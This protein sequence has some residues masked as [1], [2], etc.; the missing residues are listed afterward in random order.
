MKKF[1]VKSLYRN[2]EEEGEGEETDDNSNTNED[3][4]ENDVVEDKQKKFRY[5][6]KVKE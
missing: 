5:V 4:K 3:T 2:N 1:R 6:R